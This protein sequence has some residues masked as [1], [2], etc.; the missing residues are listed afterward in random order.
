[1]FDVIL[2]LFGLGVA[3]KQK[4]E[5]RKIY[6]GSLLTQIDAIIMEAAIKLDFEIQRLGQIAESI[7]VPASVAVSSLITMREQCDEM[8]NLVETN[9]TDLQ[10]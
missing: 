8:K 3:E 6:A 4:A 2:S 5:D 1:M 7:N 10:S 9:C